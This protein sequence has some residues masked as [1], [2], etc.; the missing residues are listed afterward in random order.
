MSFD[1]KKQ[2]ILDKISIVELISEYVDLKQKGD[3]YWGLCPFHNEKT[4]SFSVTEEKN[5]FYCFGC[6]KGGNAFDFLIEMENLSFFESFKR[7]GEKAG[8]EV[9]SKKE[10]P[11]DKIKVALFEL[12]NRISGSFNYILHNKTSSNFVRKYLLKRKIDSETINKFKLGYAPAERFWLYNFLKSKNYSDSFLEKSG[13]FSKKNKRISLFT[14]RLVFPIINIQQDTIAFSARK[15]KESD[16]GGKYINSPETSIYRKG[17]SLFG[18]HTALDEIRKTKEFYL[19]EGNFDV[20]AFYQAGIKNVV[21]P[22]GTAFTELQAKFMKRY[23]STCIIAFDSDSAGIDATIKSSI[24]LEKLGMTNK[25]I[26]MPEGKDPSEILEKEGSE[27]LNKLSKY[28][29]NTFEYIVK[30]A[31]KRYGL[32]NS[33]KKEQILKF[34]APYLG[35]LE[36]ELRKMDCFRYLSDILE[37]GVE[38]LVKDFTVLTRERRIKKVTSRIGEEHNK[39]KITLDLYLMMAL[40]ENREAFT[41]VRNTIDLD[42]IVDP[43]AKKVYILL[44]EMY[45]KD[46]FLNKNL[47]SEINDEELRDLLAYKLSI[48]EYRLNSKQLIQDGVNK[49]KE[50]NFNN[51]R[52]E[53]ENLIRKKDYSNNRIELERL[54]TEKKYLD[55]ELIRIKGNQ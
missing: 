37:L 21:A 28:P 19:V 14:N 26:A 15:L 49:I 44:E 55:E 3:K 29:I 39:I 54:L 25:V 36:T 52:R 51:Q 53:V 1:F 17:E 11:E 42:D 45:R 41:F 16:W 47:L 50:R 8:V 10:S 34:V 30:N 40:V 46:D 23:A 31:V 9:L 13:I 27:A 33:D 7:L 5:M 43:R 24:V 2:E 35:S 32:V 20:L 38:D 6:H 4:P 18:I 22:L 48:G 12:N